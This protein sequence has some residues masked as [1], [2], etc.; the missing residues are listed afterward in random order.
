VRACVRESPLSNTLITLPNATPY[1]AR[2]SRSDTLITLPNATPYYAR[3]S[4]S[5][6]RSLS[7]MRL[8]ITRVTPPLAHSTTRTPCRSLAHPHDAHALSSSRARALNRA[9]CTHP[10][11]QCNNSG[12][13]FT[14][15]PSRSF[16]HSRHSHSRLPYVHLHVYA[17]HS[18]AP[19]NAG[20]GVAILWLYMFAFAQLAYMAKRASAAD[21]AEPHVYKNGGDG[22]CLLLLW[23]AADCA[24]DT[25]ARV[26]LTAW[27]LMPPPQ[28]PPATKKK[29]KK[30]Q[31]AQRTTTEGA[32]K[33][34]E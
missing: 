15:L 24:A 14:L 23:K 25:V 6:T 2:H 1:H 8:L 31:A 10:P 22:P 32:S 4:R 33:K 26:L 18:I 3:H 5:A 17:L 21:D 27:P 7:Q 13:L 19:T 30:N 20:Y 12:S 9:C 29:M 11:T 28:P 16:I 34:T